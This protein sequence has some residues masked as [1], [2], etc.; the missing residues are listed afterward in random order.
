[1]ETKR[2]FFKMSFQ[3]NKG[4]V[5]FFVNNAVVL[6]FGGTDH[7][8][9]GTTATAAYFLDKPL[10]PLPQRKTMREYL[11]ENNDNNYT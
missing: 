11:N 10:L 8:V 1:M 7:K 6:K 4:V 2:F 5:T 9:S 3:D